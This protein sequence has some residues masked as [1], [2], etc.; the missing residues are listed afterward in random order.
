M[1]PK[2]NASEADLAHAAAEKV[3]VTHQRLVEFLRVGQTLAQIDRFVGE[4]L[5]DIGCR[6]AF[7]GYRVGRSPPFPSQACLSLNDCLVHGTAASSAKPMR[8]GDVLKIDIGV[9]Y[10]GWVGDAAWTYAF[11]ERSDLATRLMEA[12][13][14]SLKR[15]VQQLRPG[16]T[17]L[18]WARAVQ[19]HAEGECGFHLV[20][21]LG[22]HGYGRTL[23]ARPFVS[24]VVPL[25][26]NEWPDAFTP[27]TPGTLV[28][29]E[30]M[31]CAGTSETRQR[32]HEWPIHS[33]DGSLTVHYE[34]DVLITE[35]EPLVLT[36]D[37]EDLPDIVG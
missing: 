35:N 21:G 15:G 5:A 11:K 34:H 33:A 28:A 13:K 32:G 27:C 17:Y 7:V 10:K 18:D 23:H 36:R 4:T 3:V 25:S 8:A 19:S 14:E 22:G 20:R 6:S 16:K 26:A 12:G 2:V 24:N 37:L 31:L 29:V 1:I 9:F 30:P